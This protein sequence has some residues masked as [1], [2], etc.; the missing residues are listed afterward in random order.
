DVFTKYKVPF[1]TG[2]HQTK[3][4]ARTLVIAIDSI[5]PPTQMTQAEAAELLKDAVNEER[6]RAIIE[7]QKSK[8]K[9]VIQ[10][11]FRKDLEK[12]FKK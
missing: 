7:E 1:K 8:T 5:L 4:E 11:E 6:L 12:N 2:V 10:P 3:M 9:I